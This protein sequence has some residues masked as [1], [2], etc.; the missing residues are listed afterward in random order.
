MTWDGAHVLENL[1]KNVGV[2]A[3]SPIDTFM[4]IDDGQMDGETEGQVSS[5]YDRGTYKPTDRQKLPFA[6]K[7][8]GQYMHFAQTK[9]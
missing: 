1:K 8:Q 6:N 2:S 3:P 9:K 5:K 4:G 7:A